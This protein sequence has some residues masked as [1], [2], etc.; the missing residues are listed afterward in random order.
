M[1][2]T[3]RI[4]DILAE[5]EIHYK[6]RFIC[7]C[8]VHD[9]TPVISGNNCNLPLEHRHFMGFPLTQCLWVRCPATVDPWVKCPATLAPWVKCPANLGPCP[10]PASS[11]LK[12]EVSF[13]V[14]LPFLVSVVSSLCLL[15]GQCHEIFTHQ[16]FR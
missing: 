8:Y 7:S 12:L 4:L 11:C 16:L 13:C 10:T 1:L 6:P 9:S 2:L 14:L 3:G 15:M 5:K